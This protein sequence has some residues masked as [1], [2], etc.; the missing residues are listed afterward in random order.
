[1]TQGPGISLSALDSLDL[2]TLGLDSLAEAETEAE[3]SNEVE[4][5]ERLAEQ[6]KL[7][8][9]GADR[10]TDK[11]PKRQPGKGGKRRKKNGGKTKDVV[12]GGGGAISLC[13]IMNICDSSF[14]GNYSLFFLWLLNF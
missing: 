2:N 1:M 13:Q 3:L 5:L 7:T 6:M 9:L 11:R 10:Q 12:K 8:L 4:D 14:L